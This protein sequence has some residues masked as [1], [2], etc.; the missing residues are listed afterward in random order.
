M[1]E[2]LYYFEWQVAQ[3]LLAIASKFTILPRSPF[4]KCKHRRCAVSG[5]PLLQLSPNACAIKII[6]PPST[7]FFHF[8][9]PQSHA[10]VQR[11]EKSRRKSLMLHCKCRFT[12]HQERKEQ[13]RHRLRH[14]TTPDAALTRYPYPRNPASNFLRET[15]TTTNKI[16]LSSLLI[17]DDVAICVLSSKP[18]RTP[19]ATFDILH[20]CLSPWCRACKEIRT[21]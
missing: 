11:R 21:G 14:A 4:T 12:I 19:D 10:A 18:P 16:Y 9:D 15:T 8:F 3:W 20:P 2:P 13:D 1:L 6:Q 17:V 7:N 5:S